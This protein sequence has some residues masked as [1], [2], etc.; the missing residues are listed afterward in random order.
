MYDIIIIGSGPGGYEVAV[1][2]AKE[3][4]QVLVV[5]RARF[6]GTCLNEGCIP[7]KCLCHS[8]EILDEVRDAESLGITATDIKFDIQAA[9]A[10]KDSVLDNLRGGIAM[11]MK[12]PGITVVEGEAK[13]KAGDA[14]TVE[15][16]G[17]A[18]SAKHVFIATGSDTK[19]LPIP[20]A[21]SPRVL[22]SR[23][24]LQIDHVPERLVIIGGG[25]IGLEFAGI[26][27]SFGSQVTVVE[28]CKEILPPFDR[29]IAKRLRTSLKKR[30]ITFEV[31]AAV[32]EVRDEAD[33]A[34]VIYDK[35]GKL[36][37]V[38][39]DTVLMA[40]G[41]GANVGTL[42]LEE[43]GIDFTP[44]GIKVDDNM[45]TNV[46][47]VYAVGDINGL[48]QLAHAATF[49]SYRALN[50]VQGRED[51]IRLDIIPA[52]VFTTPEAAMVGLTEEALE[53]KGIA[54]KAHKAMYRANGR[55]LSMKAEDG[56]VKIL[57]A[58][59]GTILGAH[60]L[61]AHAADMVHEIAALMNVGGKFSQIAEMVH[62][63]PSLSEIILAAARS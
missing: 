61:G 30:G 48:C 49:Q 63:H 58:E 43:A 42:N 28:F 38:E 2:A 62:A 59:D 36:A 17:E 44:R 47:G 34:V 60:L 14:H 55:A 16:G 19:Y 37:E 4:L 13:F 10:R 46:P 26:F 23:E 5:E 9:M 6:G 7:T 15:V 53:A 39:A 54:Y 24:M 33:H 3:G 52:A 8:A 32:T 31:G 51:N 27:N 1:E 57:E 20:G 41:R 22:T 25:V 35:K 29:D 45:M 12:T 40:V 18:Y 56:L 11:L 50:H 21:H